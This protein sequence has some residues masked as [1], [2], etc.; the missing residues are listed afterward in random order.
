MKKKL[1]EI[2]SF[3]IRKYLAL[4]QFTPCL[5]IRGGKLQSS[6]NF[7]SSNP[8]L[9]FI[10]SSLPSY[11]NQ[12]HQH[13]HPNSSTPSINSSVVWREACPNNFNLYASSISS[14]N[15]SPYKSRYS[16]GK[17]EFRAA[18]EERHSDNNHKSMFA[19]LKKMSS[20]YDNYM[21]SPSHSPHVP[22]KSTTTSN[23]FW[24]KSPTSHRQKQFNTIAAADSRETSPFLYDR[25]LNKSFETA[26]GFMDEKENY[27]NENRGNNR[28]NAI[29]RR[30][31]TP[32]LHNIHNCD[33][34]GYDNG[35][36]SMNS[37]WCCGNFVVKQWKKMNQHY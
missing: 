31:S 29:F 17:H 5:P 27:Q 20:N 4:Q 22:R 37:T 6:K 8:A 18:S 30:S 14:L 34:G 33:A 24:S 32:Q 10:C 35:R 11:V 15:S 9:P 28:N 2:K 16:M 36:D 21:N 23:K 19:N 12:H 13:Q 1:T 25:R 26:N 7:S 3:T